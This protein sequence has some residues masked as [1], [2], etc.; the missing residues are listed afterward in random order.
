M[1]KTLLIYALILPLIVIILD[2]WS[3]FAIIQSFNAPMNICEINLRPGYKHEI[4]NLFDFSLVCNPGVSWG[5]LQGDSQ[6]KRWL[7]TFFALGMSGVLAYALTQSK[8]WLNRLSIGLIIGGAI[9]NGI[10]RAFFGAVT[11]FIDF[12]DI[13][14]RWVFNIADSAITV[15]VIG[16][17]AA[18]FIF[19]PDD[20]K[21]DQVD[22]IIKD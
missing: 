20:K 17:I 8:D 13:G 2:Q 4:S 22:E 19:K 10:D 3:K 14:F 1:K 7:L 11:D 18:S 6:L 16:L 5:Q 21:S 12:S 15:G 9:G